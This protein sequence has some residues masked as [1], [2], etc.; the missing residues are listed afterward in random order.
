[1]VPA[2]PNASLID[3]LPSWRLRWAKRIIASG[4]L[5]R[6]CCEAVALGL[7]REQDQ[8]RYSAE[9]YLNLTDRLD[10]ELNRYPEELV[11]E[12]LARHAP[13]NTLLDVYCARGRQALYFC[14]KGFR[15][16][17]I[18]FNP[19]MIE[20]ARALAIRRG[21]RADFISAEFPGV[22]LAQSYGVVYLSAWGY[23][24]NLGQ[25]RRIELLRRCRSLLV[26]RGIV[27]L[28]YRC[29][30]AHRQA[31]RNVLYWITRI[32]AAFS[33]GHLRL[34]VGDQL[35]ERELIHMFKQGEAQSEAGLAGF[36]VLEEI[37]APWRNTKFL[38]LR[39]AE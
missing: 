2:A 24:R 16:T 8:A 23:A 15:V 9:V 6:A 30:A 37:S 1:M 19:S 32:S 39:S 35:R 28:G 7:L 27:V 18:D 3:P 14:D 29:A 21:A 17:G 31:W 4:A 20:R 11:G 26:A 36:E 12:A 5:F 33:R 22:E 38:I 10:S 25:Q 34:Q 13:N